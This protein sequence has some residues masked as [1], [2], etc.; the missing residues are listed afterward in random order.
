M[1]VT[2]VMEV[3]KSC[4]GWKTGEYYSSTVCLGNRRDARLVERDP[5]VVSEITILCVSRQT[6]NSVAKRKTHET[7]GDEKSGS[8]L[9]MENKDSI[10]LIFPFYLLK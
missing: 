9:P 5:R 7:R 8:Y 3:M 6:K 2:L 4:L 1:V 10:N